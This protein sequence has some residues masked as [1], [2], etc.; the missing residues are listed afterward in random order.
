MNSYWF[1]FATIVVNL[2]MIWFMP[3]RITKR[4]VYHAWWMLSALT[5]YTDL[6]VGDIIDWYDFGPKGIQLT[7]LPIEALLPP[8]FGIIFLNF[9]PENQTRFFFYLI[10]WTSFS[11]FYEWMSVWFGFEVL[12]GWTP[13][14][15]T[16][17][18]FMVFIFLR[19]HLHYSR[20]Q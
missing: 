19:W 16:P 11:V 8:S 17:I 9:M 13:W 6:L 10:G 20:K 12:K 4:E 1:P 5:I 2:I 3:K 18:Y 15:S 7:E 14:A